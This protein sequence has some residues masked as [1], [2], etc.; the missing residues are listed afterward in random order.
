MVDNDRWDLFGYLAGTCYSNLNLVH[1][2]FVCDNIVNSFF[3]KR[4][5][6]HKECLLFLSSTKNHVFIKMYYRKTKS[7]SILM[8]SDKMSYA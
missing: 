5:F 4:K 8:K 3:Y 7:T 1:A 2:C 6:M